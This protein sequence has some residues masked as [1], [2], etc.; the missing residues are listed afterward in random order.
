MLLLL[1]AGV[2]SLCGRDAM[3]FD[4]GR[5]EGKKSWLACF[6]LLSTTGSLVMPRS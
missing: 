1:F 2:L 3:G 5:K 4:H 6:V